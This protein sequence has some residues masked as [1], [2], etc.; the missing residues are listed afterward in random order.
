[1]LILFIPACSRS[2]LHKS[3]TRSRFNSLFTIAATAIESQLHTPVYEQFREIDYTDADYGIFVRLKLNGRERG[4]I[5]F[6][7][8]VGDMNDACTKAALNA[9]FFDDRFPPLTGREFAGATIEITVI[10]ELMPLWHLHGFDP[11][12]H[13]LLYDDGS[14]RGFLQ[15]QPASGMDRDDFLMILTQK[16][17]LPVMIGESQVAYLYKAESIVAA[18]MVKDIN[19]NK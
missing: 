16:A 14:Y 17:E 9:A 7:R 12:V 1:M 15:A 8:G 10:G 19:R 3:Y 4:C 2:D 18:K 5:G 6:Y 13:S 11:D